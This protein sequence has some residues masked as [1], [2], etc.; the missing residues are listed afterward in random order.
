VQHLFLLLNC[1]S[2]DQNKTANPT[3]K[4]VEISAGRRPKEVNQRRKA[5][6]QKRNPH[7]HNI[8]EIE[9]S[10]IFVCFHQYKLNHSETIKRGIIF[11]SQF[12]IVNC[13][14]KQ[15]KYGRI[16]ST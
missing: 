13:E 9:K 14:F 15:K 10:A 1:A 12:F 2:A 6:G 3:I 8:G 11:R 4:L 7:N 16:F 5:G